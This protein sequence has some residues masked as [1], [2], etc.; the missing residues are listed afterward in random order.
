MSGME[1]RCEGRLLMMMMVMMEMVMVTA[2]L[3][4]LVP[5]VRV[6][7]LPSVPSPVQLREATVLFAQ[8]SGHAA[9][10]LR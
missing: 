3:L 9:D 8:V 2:G 1:R 4:M 5:V 6:R 10:T 7:H